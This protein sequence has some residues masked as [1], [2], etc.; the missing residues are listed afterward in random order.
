MFPFVPM[1]VEFMKNYN[2]NFL[3]GFCDVVLGQSFGKHFQIGTRLVNQP[4]YKRVQKEAKYSSMHK[5]ILGHIVR[6]CLFAY[7]FIPSISLWHVAAFSPAANNLPF[8]TAEAKVNTRCGEGC[9]AWES[10]CVLLGTGKLSKH[11]SAK[12]CTFTWNAGSKSTA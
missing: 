3:N 10:L 8:A 9:G 5:H 11:N 2:S 6:F 4:L 1:H 12:E 7:V